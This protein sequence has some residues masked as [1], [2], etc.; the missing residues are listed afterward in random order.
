MDDCERAQ[1]AMLRDTEIALLERS[2]TMPSHTKVR[3]D[4]D[5]EIC[6]EEIPLERIKA[7]NAVL[8]IDCARIEELRDKRWL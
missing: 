8:C 3:V 6:G 2:Y 7:V 1:N 5:C 4:N